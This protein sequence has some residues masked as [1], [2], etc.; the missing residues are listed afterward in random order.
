MAESFRD[1]VLLLTAERDAL[2]DKVDDLGDQLDDAR[3]IVEGLRGPLHLVEDGTDA[4]QAGDPLI[5][6]QL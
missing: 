3:I 1:R 5:D 4:V 2:Q 6:M